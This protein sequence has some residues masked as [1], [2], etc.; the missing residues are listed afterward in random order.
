MGK[1]GLEHVF[2]LGWRKEISGSLAVLAS[3]YFF[4]VG[5]WDKTTIQLPS[6]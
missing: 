5:Y 3:V 1:V 2:K 4:Q 6:I